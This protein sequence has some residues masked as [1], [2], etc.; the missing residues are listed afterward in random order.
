MSVISVSLGLRPVLLPTHFQFVFSAAL[1]R[2]WGKCF[3]GF[4]AG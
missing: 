3:D 1:M 4:T 2:V